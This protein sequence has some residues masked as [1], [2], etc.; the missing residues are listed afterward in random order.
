MRPL[1]RSFFCMIN[2]QRS[3]C[4]PT[5][6]PTSLRRI[7]LADGMAGSA[8]ALLS[9]GSVPISVNAETEFTDISRA[10]Y[11]Q[12][13]TN[14]V[15][16]DHIYDAGWVGEGESE[17]QT[18]Y[19]KYLTVDEN[20]TQWVLYHIN[21]GNGWREE[22][23]KA[24][25]GEVGGANVSGDQSLYIFPM[26]FIYIP[27]IANMSILCAKPARPAPPDLLH[28]ASLLFID[29]AVCCRSIRQS[30]RG[31]PG[32]RALHQGRRS[33]A[34]ESSGPHDPSLRHKI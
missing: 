17:P 26:S 25:V 7:H 6:A 5:P 20:G 31:L 16:I 14:G 2:F 12:L 4:R 13:V 27:D 30:S 1:Q 19:D 8:A 21:R 33:P 15:V 29:P 18:T 34:A 3:G 22:F 10:E 23:Y 28:P 9:A 11:N 32:P 24:E